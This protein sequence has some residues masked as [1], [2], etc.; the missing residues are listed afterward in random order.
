MKFRNTQNR[1]EFGAT[2]NAGVE[3]TGVETSAR[4]SRGGK[5]GSRGYGHLSKVKVT[6]FFVF[7]FLCAWCYPRAVLSR[8]A[9]LDDLVVVVSCELVCY[10]QAV[11]HT[12]LASP[13]FTS[14]YRYAQVLSSLGYCSSCQL[15]Q[16]SAT[17]WRPFCCCWGITGR[18]AI[19]C[20]HCVGWAMSIIS[21]A[22]YHHQSSSSSIVY[23]RNKPIYEIEQERQRQ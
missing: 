9:K 1:I 21:S 5:W 14:T 18:P 3:N 16:N 22:C 8:W 4:F 19:I 7:F 13:T 6:S 20:G 15:A 11:L 10:W 23:F 12:S 17:H 2:E